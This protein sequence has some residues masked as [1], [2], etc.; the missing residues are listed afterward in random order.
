MRTF[1]TNI[2]FKHWANCGMSTACVV[3]TVGKRSM[4]ERV[5]SVMGTFSAK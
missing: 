3:V 4:K 2:F 1:E 5:S